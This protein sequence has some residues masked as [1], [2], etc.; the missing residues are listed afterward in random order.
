MKNIRTWFV[1]ICVVALLSP[2]VQP[3][4]PCCID[5]CPDPFCEITA[6]E[7]ICAEIVPDNTI[8]IAK[9][10]DNLAN[11]TAEEW[12]LHFGGEY[13]YYVVATDQDWIV[14]Q[15]WM[16]RDADP[17]QSYEECACD[18]TVDIDQEIPDGRFTLTWSGSVNL[19][20]V[21]SY[22]LICTI[23][24]EPSDPPDWCPPADEST[25][26]TFTVV[27][28]D[29]VC[30]DP[31]YGDCY[32]YDP[33]TNP[34]CRDMCHELDEDEACCE[35]E[36][37]NVYM[38][39]CFRGATEGKC[40]GVSGPCCPDEA[41]PDDT[42]CCINSFAPCCFNPNTH[43]CTDDGC[44]PLCG[45]EGGE[46]CTETE[47]C[48]NAECFTDDDYNFC[49]HDTEVCYEGE[50]CQADG[51]CTPGSALADCQAFEACNEPKSNPNH[52]PSSNG[53]SS[54]FGDDPAGCGDTSFL[55]ACDQ[56]DLCYDT[57][58]ADK[59]NCDSAFYDAMVL[60]CLGSSC[61]ESC[62]GWAAKYYYAVDREGHDAYC[63][64][65]AAACVCCD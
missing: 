31:P 40:G 14:Y 15:A 42:E 62:L 27:V 20:E 39:C 33:S 16:W 65:Q 44:Q 13:I 8:T 49:C 3:A 46:C 30:A 63:D 9:Q 37:Y 29:T 6:Y 26:V 18:L 12:W 10:C 51:T 64:A 45:G 48:C 17:S 60:I 28:E 36:C 41:H 38:E 61:E 34:E 53:C 22:Q 52:T 56:H 59:A 4:Y 11:M 57:C 35:D 21:G 50:C 55:S 32:C 23:T 24:Q 19:A 43:C 2:T 1:L 54:P 7:G 5:N 25:T 58:T 47:S